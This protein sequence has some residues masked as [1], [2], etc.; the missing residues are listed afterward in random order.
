MS[1]YQCRIRESKS[2]L[3]EID[4]RDEEGRGKKKH[5]T[6]ILCV[7]GGTTLG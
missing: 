4:Q 3:R 1:E 2:E 7:G 5:P 6:S